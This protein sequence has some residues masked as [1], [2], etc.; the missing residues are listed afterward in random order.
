MEFNRVSSRFI[1]TPR[2][3]GRDRYPA[4]ERTGSVVTE[5]GKCRSSGISDSTCKEECNLHCALV[6][7]SSAIAVF[8]ISTMFLGRRLFLRS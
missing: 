5:L 6:F 1:Q 4:V 3:V 2:V 7:L 8:V